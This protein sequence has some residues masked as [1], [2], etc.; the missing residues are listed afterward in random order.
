MIWVIKIN[1]DTFFENINI[2]INY[3]WKDSYCDKIYLIE[4]RNSKSNNLIKMYISEISTSFGI[5]SLPHIS[6]SRI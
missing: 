2:G 3:M 6:E 4:G 5:L 1:K